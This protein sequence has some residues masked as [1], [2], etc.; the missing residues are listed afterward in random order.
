[1]VQVLK[2]K[3]LD[4]KSKSV[5]THYV[6]HV[7]GLHG[8]SDDMF[9]TCIAPLVEKFNN[10][11]SACCLVYGPTGSGKTFTTMRLLPLIVEKLG[12]YSNNVTWSC[13]EMYDKASF[14]FALQ[15]W[16]AT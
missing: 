9:N 11:V 3:K 15:L 2:L 10:G 5:E 14:K 13:F 6:D 4:T 12:N 16:C 1:M 7:F 8:A